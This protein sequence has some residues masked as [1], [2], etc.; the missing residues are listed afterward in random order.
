MLR[1][2]LLVLYL[3]ASSSASQTDGGS[4]WDPLGLNVPPPPQ[5]EPDRGSGWDPFG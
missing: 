2:A 3:L 1:L 4:G 5:T